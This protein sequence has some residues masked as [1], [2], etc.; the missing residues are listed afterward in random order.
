MAR[1]ARPLDP[2]RDDALVLCAARRFAAAGFSETSLNEILIEAGWS[3]SSFYHYFTDKQHLYTHVVDTL[4]RRMTGSTRIPQLD[5]LT[6]RQFWTGV[7][8]FLGALE[9]SAIAHPESRLLGVMFHRETAA[10]V[11]APAAIRRFRD[12]VSGWL[13]SA[14]RR[15][16]ALGVV[17]DDIPVDLLCEVTVAVIFAFDR[18]AVNEPRE[19]GADILDGGTILKLARR[20]IEPRPQE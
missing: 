13:E 8:S 6:A 4:A 2:V 18:W 12:T 16:R 5:R 10:S 14:I 15:G 9:A 20:L 17:R 7:E 3:K 1:T 19:L 11:D